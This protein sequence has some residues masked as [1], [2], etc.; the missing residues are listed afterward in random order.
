M[1]LSYFSVS[2][3]RSIT[4]AYKMDIRDKTVLLGKNNEGKTNV[5]RALMLAMDILKN[6]K[7]ISR[8]SIIP[9]NIYDWQNDYPIHLQDSKT[10]GDKY[11]TFRLDFELT[12]S[13]SQQL[14]E[15]CGSN[16]RKTCTIKIYLNQNNGV[17]LKISKRGK[18]E[19][20][21]VA[22]FD[23]AVF[24]VAR[25]AG[26]DYRGDFEG[27]AADRETV[28]GGGDV[29]SVEPGAGFCEKGPDARAAGAE[30][31]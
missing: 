26:G 13:E 5:L 18:N 22:G 31:V 12:S 11:T 4:R 19:L 9:R 24:W 8:K 15:I 7:S 16:I 30:F 25:D 3:F 2:N 20:S 1:K 17:E 10:S 23:A 27:G 21:G 14:Y 6:A 28:A 29:R